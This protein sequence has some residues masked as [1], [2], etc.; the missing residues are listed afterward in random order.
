MQL[1]A[2]TKVVAASCGLAGFAI[3]VIAGLVADNPADVILTRAVISMI[4]CNIV[5]YV[6]GMACERV[7][8]EGV[9]VYAAKV[10]PTKSV[11]QQPSTPDQQSRA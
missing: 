10:N 9:A 5:G 4:V 3:A 2:A 11:E 8:V 6:F 1:G 7:F